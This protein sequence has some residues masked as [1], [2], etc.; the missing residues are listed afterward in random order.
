MKK[1][2]RTI[3]LFL[4]IIMI[5]MLSV[6]AFA[7]GE[8]TYS[9]TINDTVSGHT[10]SIYQ[11]LKGDVSALNSGSGTLANTTV[12]SSVKSSYTTV[13]S[14]IAQLQEEDENGDL[15]FLSGGALSKAAYSLIDTTKAVK[16]A[17]GTGGTVT[18]EDLA[19][20]Y[21]V[22][23]D[24]YSTGSTATDPISENVVAV[25][26]DT[27]VNLKPD[28]P[29]IEKTITDTDNNAAIDTDKTVD[30]AAIG[31]TIEYQVTGTVPDTAAYDYYYYVL[32][33]TLSAGLT[34]DTTS[35]VVTIGGTTLSKTINPTGEPSTGYIVNTSTDST[36]GVTTFQLAIRNMKNYTAGDDIIV[37]YNA[38]VNENAVIGT[39]ANTNT[40]KLQY[41]NNPN[42]SSGG[43]YLPDEDYPTG[44]TPEEITKT[45]VTEITVYKVD[46]NK[47]N[48][49]GAEFTLTGSN[50]NKINITVAE[51]FVEDAENGTWYLLKDGSYTEKDPTDLT[52]SY[53]DDPTTKYV[54]TTTTTLT[55]KSGSGTSSN[56]SASVGADGV[57]TFTGL[58]AGE[59]TLSE[60]VTPAGYNTIQPITFT[61]SA[62]YANSAI[63]WSAN[64]ALT[65]IDGTGVFEIT[66]ENTKGTILPST[67]GM[68]TTVL[69]I[70]GICLVLGAGLLL[71]VRYRK[72]R[73]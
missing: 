67:G 61:I 19:G 33:D 62:T 51:S 7:E 64:K 34:L 37:K 14:V 5:M 44:E 65:Y 13:E 40:V 72:N 70:V 59:Y 31:D 35:F 20:G 21:Y 24:N 53:Y 16:T 6:T 39:D 27:T 49:K 54:K 18:V 30:T 9:L 71:V 45:Y 1:I 12:G 4:T 69:Y 36:T 17:D 38:T 48:L 68:G 55:D 47:L 32:N 66:I 25:V 42:N 26:G 11:I 2:R 60:T 58:N 15:Q 56:V 63:T 73:A 43:G 8:T 29:S 23:V 41:S 28:T 57:L 3:S 46:E 50:L 52:E 22:I 10:Y